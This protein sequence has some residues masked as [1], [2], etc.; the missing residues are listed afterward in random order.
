MLAAERTTTTVSRSMTVIAKL[1][2]FTTVEGFKHA[3]P[4]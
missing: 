2:S 1:A 3:G 4:V